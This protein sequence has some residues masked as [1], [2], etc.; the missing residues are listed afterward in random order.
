MLSSRPESDDSFKSD[1]DVEKDENESETK[2]KIMKS[3]LS[4]LRNLV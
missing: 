3:K 4:D 2:K 1:T